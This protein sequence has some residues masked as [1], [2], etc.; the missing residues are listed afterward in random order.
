MPNLTQN[1]FHLNAGAWTFSGAGINHFSSAEVMLEPET[2]VAPDVEKSELPLG[3]SVRSRGGRVKML[4]H[5]MTLD[6][7][8][9]M[10]GW[11]GNI[12]GTTIRMDTAYR[13]LPHGE[14]AFASTLKDGTQIKLSWKNAT[15]VPTSQT[16]AL[17][18]KGYWEGTLEF[19]LC[20]PA[21]D[22][23]IAGEI[24]IGIPVED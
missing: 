13:S 22:T 24:E 21:D 8:S 6:N 12:S 9:W 5:D 20:A 19:V 1:K 14:L 15:A 7:L 4:V 2:V 3:V 10:T 18:R 11:N 23:G 17:S 16:W